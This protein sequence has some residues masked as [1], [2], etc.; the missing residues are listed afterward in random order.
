[1]P[2][3][4]FSSDEVEEVAKNKPWTRQR[5]F[6]D[7]I[8]PEHMADTA[9]VYARAAG[10]ADGAGD[11]A[12]HATEVAFEGGALNGESLVDDE[13]RI[14]ATTR[15]LSGNGRD[16]DTVVGYLV[17]AMNRAL[18]AEEE[19]SGLILGDGGLEE[20][21]SR[22]I[23]A[24]ISEWDGW[25]SAL[26]AAVS[27]PVESTIMPRIDSVDV[28]YRG[29]TLTLTPTHPN[30]GQ[31]VYSLPGHLADE[32]RQRH[33]RD[34]ADDA[35]RT[36]ADIDDAIE[37]YR[38]R[39]AEYGGELGELG[40]D[41]SEGPLGLFTSEDQ[42]VWTADMLAAELDKENPDPEALRRYTETLESIALGIWDNPANADGDP[43]R[44]LT[45]AER[46]YLSAFYGR[47]DADDLVA[48]GRLADD[49]GAGRTAAERAANGLTM[50]LDWRVGGYNPET[51]PD[52]IPDA[53]RPF[54]YD[55]RDSDLF[56]PGFPVSFYDDLDEFNAFGALMGSATVAPGDE[57]GRDMAEAAL[58]VQDRTNVQ[59]T[60][61]ATTG[62]DNTFSSDLLHGVSLNTEV[63]AA[64]LNDEDYRERLLG[65]TWQDSAGVGDLITSG[66]TVPA[67]VEMNDEAARAYVEA[68]FNVVRD[69]GDHADA[70][71]GKDFPGHA[72]HKDLQGAIADTTLAYL[73]MITKPDAE[74]S[75]F[76]AGAGI[77]DFTDPD[78]LGNDYRYSFDLDQDDRSSLFQL[79]GQ[80]DKDVQ[81]TFST[82][83]AAWQET[84]A[85]NAFVREQQT[86]DGQD[87]AFAAIGRA[88]G[89]M[90]RAELDLNI[91]PAASARTQSNLV[92]GLAAAGSIVKDTLSLTPAGKAAIIATTYGIA[93]VV[94]LELPPTTP[95]DTS[96]EEAQAYRNGDTIPRRLIAEA[97]L[98]ADYRGLGDSELPDPTDKNLNESDM[99][100]QVER[101]EHEYDAYR[102]AMRE[103]YR[104][105]V[106]SR[107]P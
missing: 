91:E 20:A 38:T 2:D 74:T 43:G 22:H 31:N 37:A 93:S 95:P 106:Y 55:Y 4:S 107:T 77:G 85:Y 64:L 92:G 24:A 89:L 100:R 86:G 60:L 81:D 28:S 66:T 45:E 51:D 71:L 26:E 39:L 63:S 34:C 61:G 59:Y 50:L 102:D 80:M 94:R 75:E 30:A 79:L 56:D 105:E 62:E 87:D 83:V 23:T 21:R 13:G 53:V 88:E 5:E 6:S 41:L 68:A 44:P 47:L 82:G 16:M 90:K 49:G 3:F 69:A 36:Y 54:I 19:V 7:E 15:G 33:L 67:G 103:A 70:I 32:I 65:M 1:M 98:Q 40:Y 10:E 46:A 18:A 11:L 58:E 17:G 73:N 78:L 104:G 14:D 76:F 96:G 35:E 97:A 99:L 12:R 84:T 42:A 57:F 52:R 8:D 72:A 101:L 29:R 27:T 25:Q 9:T 48:L